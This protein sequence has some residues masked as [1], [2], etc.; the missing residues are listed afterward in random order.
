MTQMNFFAR[1]KQKLK[2]REQTCGLQRG[3]VGGINWEIGIGIYTVLGIKYMTSENLVFS[4]ELSSVLSG[5]LYGKEV[6]KRG[7]LCIHTVDSLFYAAE[8][9]TIL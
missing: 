6:Q 7:D 3:R 5:D 4:K 8:T 2:C 1:Q 9:N